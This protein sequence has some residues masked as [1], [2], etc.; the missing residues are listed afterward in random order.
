M[1]S[2]QQVQ[3]Y[4]DQVYGALAAAGTQARSSVHLTP[5]GARDIW[6]DSDK[7]NLSFC[8][9][10]DMGLY[11][12]KNYGIIKLA[13][14]EAC[15]NW[16]Q[17]ANVEF[18]YRPN[19]DSNAYDG[20]P[21]VE[22]TVRLFDDTD[23]LRP[24]SE[25]IQAFAFF[26]SDAENLHVLHI[27]AGFMGQDQDDNVFPTPEAQHRYWVTL[28]THELGHILGLRHEHVWMLNSDGT[29]TYF[30]DRYPDGSPVPAPELLT[31]L[32][33]RS[34]MAYTLTNQG[35]TLFN[36]SARVSP[37]DGVG[38][39][40]TTDVL[41]N[42]Y[43]KTSAVTEE[44]VLFMEDELI[45]RA[46]YQKLSGRFCV[47]SLNVTVQNGE[48]KYSAVFRK[49]GLPEN[50]GVL[51][52]NLDQP[53]F[54]SEVFKYHLM[55]YRIRTMDFYN[56]NE[57]R[58]AAVME[59][60]NGYYE[61]YGEYPSEV[62]YP[63]NGTSTLTEIILSELDENRGVRTLNYNPDTDTYFIIAISFKG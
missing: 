5:S 26:P 11:P 42:G 14:L 44:R 8:I 38:T 25:T 7:L 54:V 59:I 2:L 9:D 31:A 24:M 47:D 37:L 52:L 36:R 49:N 23:F 30:P 46:E 13:M 62:S 6:N 57:N 60:D 35:G 55:G 61:N 43:D 45:L 12:A 20:N 51:L 15:A 21:F 10:N 33:T 41:E 27:N 18:K 4:Y 58:Y 28:I 32:D 50:P 48:I 3:E 16:E 29:Y 34:I 17:Y 63:A 1:S 22:F 53:N 40:W 39:F 19:Q 56:Y